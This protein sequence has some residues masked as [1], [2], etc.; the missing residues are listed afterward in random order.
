MEL[1]KLLVILITVGLLAYMQYRLTV[2]YDFIYIN[3]PVILL[4]YEAFVTFSKCRI[5]HN[6]LIVKT[7]SESY[8]F[9]TPVFFSRLRENKQRYILKQTARVSGVKLKDFTFE[10]VKQPEVLNV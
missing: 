6:V 8:Y 10:V 7:E 2:I 4:D 1:T 9:K 5:N 3:G